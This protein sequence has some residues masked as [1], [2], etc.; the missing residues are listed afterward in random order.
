MNKTNIPQAAIEAAMLAYYN[1]NIQEFNA[2]SG[3]WS[4]AK[5][6]IEDMKR[7]LQAALPH[8]QQWQPIETAPRDGRQT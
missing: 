8:L 1:I 5:N 4:D 7:A 6:T 2:W 3:Y